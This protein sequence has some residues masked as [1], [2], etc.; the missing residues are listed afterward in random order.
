[1]HSKRHNP[2]SLAKV[3]CSDW[4]VQWCCH[5]HATPKSPGPVSFDTLFATG[6]WNMAL[7][8]GGGGA[9]W[10]RFAS[11]QFAPTAPVPTVFVGLGSV[12]R[13]MPLVSACPSV[14]WLGVR[15]KDPSSLLH[16]TTSAVAC[17]AVGVQT[18]GQAHALVP[19]QSAYRAAP[20]LGEGK[21]VGGGGGR[22]AVARSRSPLALLNRPSQKHFQLTVTAPPIPST[23]LLQPLLWARSPSN[24]P[25]RQ[26][27]VTYLSGTFSSCQHGAFHIFSDFSQLLV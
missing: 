23:R 26:C 27:Q 17:W 1:M 24:T 10:V 21:M 25:L 13:F 9:H 2:R 7:E 19:C 15:G 16:C 11:P 22:P 6:A 4:Y 20:R 12:C 3:A 8:R 14:Q 5:L 18:F